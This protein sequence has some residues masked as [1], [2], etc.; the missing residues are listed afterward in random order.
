[1][2]EIKA[3]IRPEQVDTV[4]HALYHENIGH[5]TVVHVRSLGRPGVGL[6]PKHRA[7]SL[8]SGAWYTDMVKIEVACAETEVGRLVEVIRTAARTGQPGDGI[9]FVAPLDRAVKIRTGEQ[10]RRVL[11]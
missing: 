7:L 9:V 6:D 3:Y 10:G 1:M 11:Q 8:E 2:R 5:V 4:I